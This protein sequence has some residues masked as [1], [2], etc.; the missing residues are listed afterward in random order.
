MSEVQAPHQNS[1]NLS[2]PSDNYGAQ[3]PDAIDVPVQFSLN[4]KQPISPL[5]VRPH[6][7]Y[8]GSPIALDLP[9]TARNANLTNNSVVSSHMEASVQSIAERQFDLEHLPTE[10]NAE[11]KNQSNIERAAIATNTTA[12]NTTI[13]NDAFLSSSSA[14]ANSAMVSTV[15]APKFIQDMYANVSSETNQENQEKDHSQLA[16][17]GS[18]LRRGVTSLAAVQL[19]QFPPLPRR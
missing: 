11:S 10:L 4:A 5:I 13:S 12:T 14:L 8:Q 6:K 18:S 16:I 7:A 15:I 2:E 19:P 17:A 9:K 3:Q 1:N